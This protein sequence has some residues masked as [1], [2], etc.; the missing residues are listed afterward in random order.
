MK[1]NLKNYTYNPDYESL[2]LKADTYFQEVLKS[3]DTNANIAKCIVEYLI[4]QMGQI[5]KDIRKSITI[6]NPE[7][8]TDEEL[9]DYIIGQKME[10]LNYVLYKGGKSTNI[11]RFFENLFATKGKDGIPAISK[12]DG[13]RF[14][15]VVNR[16]IPIV[17][18][19]NPL[20]Y[21]ATKTGI[22]ENDTA[23]EDRRY[24]KREQFI[25]DFE[26]EKTDDL[27]Y[28][29]RIQGLEWDDD[30]LCS[31]IYLPKSLKDLYTYIREGY[32]QKEQQRLL[33]AKYHVE[34]T[35]S[36]L[37]TRTKHLY[38]LLTN[39][40]VI[41]KRKKKCCVCGKEKIITDFTKDKS[42]KDGYSPRC[43]Q[44]DKERKQKK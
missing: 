6:E 11:T 30:R 9:Q 26:E 20:T 27:K 41:D 15:V 21:L 17:R 23:A 8:D 31:Y 12:L 22:Y 38:K 42:R 35:D 28:T 7:T 29:D 1:Y 19:R 14:C 33:S 40:S 10:Y 43:K 16:G 44:C 39:P 36:N 25:E 37:R 32:T 5:E 24:K 3:K 4:I 18:I 2:A 34:V 13:T